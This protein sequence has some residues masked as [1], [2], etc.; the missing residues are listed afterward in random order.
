MFFNNFCPKNVN[1]IQFENNY[2]QVVAKYLYK[3][4]TP[5]FLEIIVLLHFHSQSFFANASLKFSNINNRGVTSANVA[6]L[7]SFMQ[8]IK[9]HLLAKKKILFLILSI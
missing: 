2:F 7:L 6:I 9:E 5:T 8:L 1:L 3:W 4:K